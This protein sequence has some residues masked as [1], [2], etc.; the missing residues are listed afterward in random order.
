MASRE[1]DAHCLPIT[2]RIDAWL[3]RSVWFWQHHVSPRHQHTMA[4]VPVEQGGVAHSVVVAGSHRATLPPPGWRQQVAHHFAKEAPA[5]WDV[6]RGF[7]PDAKPTPSPAPGMRNPTR[8]TQRLGNRSIAK[9]R[10]K[11]RTRR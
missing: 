3:S 2:T 7:S 5:I 6:S 4:V 9:E 10:Q 8:G 11:R 1:A